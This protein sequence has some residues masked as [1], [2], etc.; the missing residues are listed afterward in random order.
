MIFFF[1]TS[2]KII[3]RLIRWA[4][5]QDCS[6]FALC[7]DEHGIVLHA[8]SDGVKIEWIESFRRKHEIVHELSV[9]KKFK[10]E[11]WSEFYRDIVTRNINLPYDYGA[12][13][14]FPVM[15]VARCLGFK[16]KHNLWGSRKAWLCVELAEVIKEW[17]IIKCDWP[18]N[19]EITTPHELYLAMRKSKDVEETI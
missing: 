5:G 12:L 2:K 13:F 3:S 15:L 19:F 11:K 6:H 14:F 4:T 18:D 17:N 8:Q 9:S 10:L 16:Y 7:F 1:T